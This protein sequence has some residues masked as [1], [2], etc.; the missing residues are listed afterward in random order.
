MGTVSVQST[1][2]GNIG[3]NSTLR[4]ATASGTK[5]FINNYSLKTI[6]N[7]HFSPPDAASPYSLGGVPGNYR[8]IGAYGSNCT[9]YINY[10]TSY[11]AWA[12]NGSTVSAGTSL[13]SSQSN[14]GYRMWLRGTNYNSYSYVQLGVT[15]DYGYSM[16]RWNVFREDG[17]Y[18]T[19]IST[20][21]TFLTMYSSSY[22]NAG[23]YLFQAVCT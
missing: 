13:T 6:T 20:T 14:A 15:A 12:Y 9:V 11:N 16:N 17:I 2:T 3:I 1:V 7:E 23:Y 21:S 10:P 4:P 22:T 18:Y 8:V 19:Q 5:L